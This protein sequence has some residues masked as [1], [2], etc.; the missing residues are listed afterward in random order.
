M[1]ELNDKELEIIN[2]GISGA[3]CF[4][5]SASTS[6]MGGTIGVIAGGIFGPA[7]MVAGGVFGATTGQRFGLAMCSML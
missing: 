7:G 2:G 4:T 3:G 6:I 1:Q 5:L